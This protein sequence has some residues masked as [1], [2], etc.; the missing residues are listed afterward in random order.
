MASEPLTW[1][2]VKQLA[3]DA[4]MIDA[5]GYF[6]GEPAEPDAR[7]ARRAILYLRHALPDWLL[8]C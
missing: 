8:C 6:N 5:I 2:R 4:K 7:A 1:K 3:L